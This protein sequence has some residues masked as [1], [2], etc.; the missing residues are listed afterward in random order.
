M[1]IEKS[2]AFADMISLDTQYPAP[3]SEALELQEL[4][5][6]DTANERTAI[7][8]Q[9]Y[10]LYFIRHGEA[11]HNILEKDAASAA[12][13]NEIS[14][15]YAPD[16]DHVKQAME[17]ARKAILN[18]EGMEDPPLSELGMEEAR[19]AKR[20]LESLIDKCNLPPVQEV[21]VSPLQRALKTA[22]IIFPAN[23]PRIRVKEELEERH[24]GLACDTAAPL[25]SIN[26]PSFQHFSLSGLRLGSME[27]L[28]KGASHSSSMDKMDALDEERV[29]MD[30]T[31]EELD[32]DFGLFRL[33]GH[34]GEDDLW[35]QLDNSEL[36]TNEENGSNSSSKKKIT[37][38]S[39]NVNMKV[40]RSNNK[41]YQKED[42][43]MLRKRTKK[44]FDLLAKTE[45]RSI[46]L[47][48][49]GWCALFIKYNVSSRRL[50]C[51][52]LWIRTQRLPPGIGTRSSR[53][54]GCATL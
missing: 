40:N 11:L 47:I 15:G 6:G 36:V 27:H 48:G 29:Q 19:R 5:A 13:E 33:S 14:L 23:G 32:S 41:S 16:S 51:F 10:M 53:L 49:K 12:R 25:R 43:D 42:R 20:E 35:E 30:G 4:R 52:S 1:T 34:P 38:A 45:S 21:W 46:C 54:F 26:R 50:N 7:T 31:V 8:S 2:V 24:T 37:S 44:L 28:L 22:S 9:E 18:S 39:T 3:A 17:E